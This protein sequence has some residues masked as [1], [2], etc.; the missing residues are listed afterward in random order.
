ML[1]AVDHID[2]RTPDFEGTV[3][4]LTSLGLREVRRLDAARGSVEMA[5]PGDGQV[6][7]EIRPE[8]GAESAYIHHVAFA[9]TDLDTVDTLVSAGVSFTKSKQFVP[10]TGRTV[11]NGVDPGGMTWQLTD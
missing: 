3:A 1:I 9:L 5:L 8:A 6:V 4:Y 2:V 11:T 7:L 10:A